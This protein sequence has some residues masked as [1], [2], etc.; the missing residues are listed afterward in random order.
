VKE[1]FI[2]VITV[3]IE[4]ELSYVQ[5]FDSMATAE[6]FIDS[7]PIKLQ[8]QISDV[9]ITDSLFIQNNGY[10]HFITVLNDI[11][12]DIAVPSVLQ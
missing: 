12:G 3:F 7:L 1:R 11:D 6:L 2:H 5:T 4:G 9:P 10:R 8:N